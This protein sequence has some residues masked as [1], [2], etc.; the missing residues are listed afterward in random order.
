MSPPTVERDRRAWYTQLAK[1]SHTRNFTLIHLSYRNA[2][3]VRNS[4]HVRCFAFLLIDN[5]RPNHGFVMLICPRF[6]VNTLN[7]FSN[8][9]RCI[10]IRRGKQWGPSTVATIVVINVYKRFLFLDKKR[11]Y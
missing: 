11:V 1:Y 9:K 5:V 8:P 6:G 10:P 3:L 2:G 7:P 4:L